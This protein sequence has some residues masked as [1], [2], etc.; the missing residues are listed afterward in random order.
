MWLRRKHACCFKAVHGRET[1]NLYQVEGHVV[2]KRTRQATQE[3]R[4]YLGEKFA[5]NW[6]MPLHLMVQ[7]QHTNRWK[8]ERLW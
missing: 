4:D 6:V 7:L 1:D 5:G 3:D 8:R 2:P